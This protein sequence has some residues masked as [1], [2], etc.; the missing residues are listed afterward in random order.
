MEEI[1]NVHVADLPTSARPDRRAVQ[2][3]DRGLPG[4]NGAIDSQR[5]L[6]RLAEQGYDGPIT[7]E[8][9]AGCRSLAGLTPEASAHDVATALHAVWPSTISGH[10]IPTHT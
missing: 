7:T 3:K 5:L 9:M 10:P 1:V 6:A 4:E 8:P 2:D